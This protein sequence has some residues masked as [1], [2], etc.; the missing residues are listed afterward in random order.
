MLK[1][2][3]VLATG[4][5]LVLL[6]AC[7]K[8]DAPPPAA[9]AATEPAPAA[10]GPAMAEPD[11]NEPAAAAEEQAAEETSGEEASAALDAPATFDIG[12]IP[13]SDQPLPEWPYVVLPSGYAFDRDDVSRQSKDLARVPVWTGQSLLWVEGRTF[14]DGVESTDGKTYSKFEVRKNLQQAIEALGGVRLGQRSFDRTTYQANRA[15]LDD[16]RQEF[17]EMQNAYWYDSD[18]DTYVIRRADKAIWVVFGSSNTRGAVL[19]AEGPLPEAG[20][21]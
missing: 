11:T 15:E 8:Q 12:A 14:S 18:A 10:A 21:Q 19:V 3:T 17:S 4:V 2:K 6:A 5:A 20:A 1:T 9:D 16:F 7:G 13:V